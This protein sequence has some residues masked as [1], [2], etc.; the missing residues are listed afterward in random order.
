MDRIIFHCD[1]NGYF[2]SVEELHS[3]HLREVP[4][5]VC[6]NPES[7]RGIITAKNEKAKKFGIQTAETV[8]SALRKCPDLVLR[9]PRHGEYEKYCDLANG[10]YLQYTDLVEPASIDESYLDVTG[11]L[12]LF[13]GDAKK[14]ADEIRERIHTE[15]GLTIS[16]GV[17][18]N[19]FFAKMGS[20]MK[21]PNATTVISR[22]N[23]KTKLWS[24]PI[25]NMFMVGKA[26]EATLYSMNIRTIGALAQGEPSFLEKKLGKHGEYLYRCANGMD[27]AP[28]RAY[29]DVEQPKT[30]G[31]GMTFKR[32]LITREDIATAIKALS[33]TVATRLRNHQMKCMSVQVTIKAPNLVVI[34][35]QKPLDAPTHLAADLSKVCIELIEK[36]WRI[37]SP[38]RLL[39]V[40]AQKLVHKDAAVEQLTLFQTETDESRRKKEKL[41]LAVDQVRRR[42]GRASLTTAAIVKNDL[43]INEDFG[44]DVEE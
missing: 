36:N 42:F 33:D 34:T 44:I 39:T 19:K 1:M 9:P 24:L 29:G 18:F 30:I 17:S 27:D 10:I 41:E 16:V 23:Y 35:R 43:G 31:N 6:G 14:L 28:V 37:G 7:R 11:S 40:T 26:A 22:E 5:A 21:K 38:I 13:G 32:D 3:P 12:Y 8:Y 2:A 4:M 20:E 15:L 25:G